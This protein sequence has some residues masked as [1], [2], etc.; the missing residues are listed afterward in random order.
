[1]SK[2]INSMSE[3]FEAVPIPVYP[4]TDYMVVTIAPGATVEVAA[5]QAACDVVAALAV[6]GDVDVDGTS[7]E[8]LTD[9]YVSFCVPEWH[10]SGNRQVVIPPM[11]TIE[12]TDEQAASS[13][14]REFLD[15]GKGVDPDDKSGTPK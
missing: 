11:G 13:G 2:T 12:I 14:M 3:D 5:E 6:K 1:M 8:N 7:I 15:S 10:L 9:E 4:Y